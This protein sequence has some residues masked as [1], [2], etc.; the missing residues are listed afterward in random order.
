[1]CFVRCK[2]LASGQGKD[3]GG[4]A[5][6][7]LA[8]LRNEFM[9]VRLC[10][11]IELRVPG[12][13]GPFPNCLFATHCTYPSPFVFPNIPYAT[14]A[15]IHCDRYSPPEVR[16]FGQHGH[17]EQRFVTSSPRGC[18]GTSS[19]GHAN[20][21]SGRRCACTLDRS[22]THGHVPWNLGTVAK[23]PVRCEMRPA[24]ATRCN[25]RMSEVFFS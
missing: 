16:S 11:M 7:I 19:S 23:G 24:R 3:S 14:S 17:Y 21:C 8:S 12:H 2:G 9:C 15:P 22:R 20:D 5:T 1:M 10:A 4:A 6:H 18:S 25:E 13:A